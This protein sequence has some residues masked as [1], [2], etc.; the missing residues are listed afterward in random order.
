MIRKA[1]SIMRSAEGE[2]LGLSNKTGRR[3][4]VTKYDI[5]V[6]EFLAQSLEKAFPGICFIGEETGMTALPE[7]GPFCIVDP[8]D[9]TANFTKNVH[10]SAVSI[11]IGC[12]GSLVL[13]AIFDPYLDE[14]FL[15]E[16]GKGASVNGHRIQRDNS[17]HLKDSMVC[18]GTSPYDEWLAEDTFAAAEWAYGQALDV[19]RTG[20]AS[21]DVAYSAANRFDL[22]FEGRLSPWDQ[23]AA[24]LLVRESGGA[25]FTFDGKEPPLDER[26]TIVSGSKPAVERFLEEVASGHLYPH[27]F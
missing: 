3:D 24:N 4:F 5:Q 20:T 11:A 6:Q 16:T 23:A 26:C 13:G 12:D 10:H 9:G 17:I 1:G 25:I 8:I 19:R 18:F 22:F 15:A 14:L 21:L 27:G 7:C 2:A